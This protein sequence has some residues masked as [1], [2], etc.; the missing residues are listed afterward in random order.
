MDV[1]VASGKL[2]RD[3]K[4]ENDTTS[5]LSCRNGVEVVVDERQVSL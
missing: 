3:H 5:V 4:F 1:E 2:G